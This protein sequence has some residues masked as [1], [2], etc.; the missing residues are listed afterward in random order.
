MVGEPYVV[1]S[2]D[3]HGGAD[4]RDYRPYLEASYL[5][6]FDARQSS[7]QNPFDDHS[8]D[9]A[10]RKSGLAQAVHAARDAQPVGA[11]DAGGGGGTQ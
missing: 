3:C 1:I 2:A 4:V 9:R 5:D 11:R 7:Y 10:A 6:D 8:D